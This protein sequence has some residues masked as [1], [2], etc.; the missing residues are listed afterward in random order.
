LKMVS[1]YWQPSGD[2][3]FSSMR[4]RFTSP[5]ILSGGLAKS[6]LVSYQSHNH[7][8]FLQGSWLCHL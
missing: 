3:S 6:F 5:S 4:N 7:F 2:I 8:R 1:I